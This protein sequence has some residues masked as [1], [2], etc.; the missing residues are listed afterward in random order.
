[1]EN[2]EQHTLT[3]HLREERMHRVRVVEVGLLV[4]AIELAT[5]SLGDAH[6][7]FKASRG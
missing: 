4:Q 1:M 5:V 7:G 3:L 6:P 2:K